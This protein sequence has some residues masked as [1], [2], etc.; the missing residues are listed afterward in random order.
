LGFEALE[1]LARSGRVEVLRAAV[2]SPEAP[3]SLLERA[4][5]VLAGPS[6]VAAVLAGAAEALSAQS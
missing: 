4:D 5:V 3:A 6:E 1:S 2:A